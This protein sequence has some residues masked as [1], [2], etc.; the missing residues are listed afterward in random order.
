MFISS[1][2]ISLR[3]LHSVPLQSPHAATQF[4][5]LARQEQIFEP[6]GF[7]DDTLQLHLMTLRMSFGAG[8]SSVMMGT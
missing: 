8:G 7:F 5:P 6:H 1:K 4:N 3:F 2:T